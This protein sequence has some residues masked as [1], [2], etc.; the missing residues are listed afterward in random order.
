MATGLEFLHKNC[1]IHLD[2]KPANILICPPHL[3]VK[4]CDFGNSQRLKAPNKSL[5][6]KN[7]SGTVAFMAPEMLKRNSVSTQSDVYALAITI[8]QLLHRKVPYSGMTNEQQVIY[9]VVKNNLR[10]S[11]EENASPSERL[12]ADLC[13]WFHRRVSVSVVPGKEKNVDKTNPNE[14]AHTLPTT[15]GL[16]WAAENNDSEDFEDNSEINWKEVFSVDQMK[17]PPPSSEFELLYQEL[18]TKC[19]HRKPLQRPTITEVLQQLNGLLSLM[20]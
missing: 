12:H 8:W 15:D 19:W 10:P 13:H 14:L 6:L 3:L 1:I 18:Y 11:G 4:L 20:P 2:V 5:T 16:T 17:H 9:G 7:L